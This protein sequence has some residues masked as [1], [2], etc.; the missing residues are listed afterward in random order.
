MTQLDKDDIESI[1]LVKFDFLGLRTLTILDW[2]LHTI[3]RLKGKALDLQAIALNDQATFSLLQSC[4][5]N[6]VFQLESQGMQSLIRKLKPDCFDDVVALVALFRPGPLQSGMVDDFVDRKH[7]RQ[8]VTYLHPDLKPYLDNTYGVILYQEQVMYIARV[9]GG[10]TLGEADLLRRA[11]GKKKPEV[12]AKQRSVFVSGCVKH[13]VDQDLAEHIFD[14]M[15]KFSAYAFPKAHSVAYALLSFQTAYLKAH[16][17]AAFMAAVLSSECDNTDKVKALIAET[18]RMKL[19]VLAPNIQTDRL[20][21]WVND[22]GEIQYGLAAI[23]GMGVALV[24]RIELIRSEGG[25]FSDLFSF[26]HR[27]GASILSRKHLEVLIASGSMDIWGESRAV[28]QASVPRALRYA[29]QKAARL[30]SGQQ[31]LLSMMGSENAEVST[32]ADVDYAQ[33]M[34]WDILTRLAKE[35]DA[36]G[37]YFSKHPMQV[38]QKELHSMGVYLV[39]AVK[40]RAKGS[41]MLSG[42]VKAVRMKTSKAG[43][44]MAF[45]LMEDGL[46][47]LDVAFYGE[48]FERYGSDLKKNK[49]L[50]VSGRL[51]HDAYRNCQRVVAQSVTDLDKLRIDLGPKLVLQLNDIAALNSLKGCLDDAPQGKSEVVLHYNQA[52]DQAD[53]QAA[54]VPLPYRL[55]LTESILLQIKQ[56]PGV[57]L[58]GLQYPRD[59]LKS[60]H[61]SQS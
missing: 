54:S 23:K 20:H 12:M 7:A 22:A 51:E 25:A 32:V 6:A 44:R 13:G 29:Q 14:L 33:A 2:T 19:S 24:E 30:A 43:Q 8:E 5:T 37:F 39:H 10:Y 52:A 21:F 46:A 49:V 41:V 34:D 18:K 3:K 4:H 55:L 17:P 26:C 31:D 48:A 36:L 42:F 50:V 16:H 28:L 56:L 47:E 40:G 15:E 11:M 38:Y 27:V 53:N 58:L 9:L 60:A 45:V 59:A 1:G 57:F 61:F 35:C